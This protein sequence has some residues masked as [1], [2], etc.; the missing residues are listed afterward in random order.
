MVPWDNLRLLSCIGH[1]SI[2]ISIM[3]AQA[4]QKLLCDE[5]HASL[6]IIWKP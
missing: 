2:M 5:G 1:V 6:L 4:V 3:L